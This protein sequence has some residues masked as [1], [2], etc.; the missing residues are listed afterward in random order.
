MN[1]TTIEERFRAPRAFEARFGGRCRTC[2]AT[3]NRGD[4]IM[5]EPFKGG[6]AWCLDCGLD[7]IGAPKWTGAQPAK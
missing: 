2:G 1:P 3:W 7:F 5:L 6:R 4:V